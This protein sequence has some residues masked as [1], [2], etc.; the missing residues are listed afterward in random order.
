MT[1]SD[2]SADIRNLLAV[3]WRIY[4]SHEGGWRIALP[5]LFLLAGFAEGVGI[6]LLLPLF[7]ALNESASA[8][9]GV[10]R[11]MAEIMVALGLPVT[12]GTLLVLLV[13]VIVMKAGL[14]LVVMRHVAKIVVRIAQQF[15][16]SLIDA[17]ISAR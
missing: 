5:I 17:L 16:L 15:R 6:T 10:S 2:R 13:A 14:L 8:R 1:A 3:M 11:T 9:S 12:L 4:R 7:I